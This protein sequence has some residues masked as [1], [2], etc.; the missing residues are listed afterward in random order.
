MSRR[1]I[2]LFVAIGIFT[3]VVWQLPTL[4]KVIP[5]RYVAAYFP[6]PV[7]ALAAREHVEMLPTANVVVDSAALLESTPAAMAFDLAEANSTPSS[8]S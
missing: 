7:Q 3:V 8:K 4:L 6:K 5:S 2:L 1:L